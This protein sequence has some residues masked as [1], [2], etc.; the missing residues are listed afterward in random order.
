MIGWFIKLTL[1]TTI[2][3][4]VAGGGIAV[5]LGSKPSKVAGEMTR[6]EVSEEASKQFDSKLQNFV[7]E[8]KTSNDNQ[9][10]TVTLT[11]EEVASKVA[12]IAE[13]GKSP[14]PVKDIEVNLR[15][16]KIIVAGNLETSGINVKVAIVAKVETKEGK[17]QVMVE[18]VDFGQLPVPQAVKDQVNQAV[19]NIDLSSGNIPINLSDIRVENGQLVLEGSKRN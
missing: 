11:Q 9:L 19:A 10:R 5:F 15:N 18:A 3:I 8:A 2:L 4:V 12:E 16:E 7:T 13:N 14:L 17:P 1:L 6:V